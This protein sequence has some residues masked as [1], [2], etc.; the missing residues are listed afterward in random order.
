MT[1][2]DIKTK[3][4][5]CRNELELRSTCSTFLRQGISN[6]QLLNCFE[7]LRS[8]NRNTPQEDIWINVMDALDGWCSI[9]YKIK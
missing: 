8:Y 2:N 5:K 7:E 1:N 4:L 3:I 6:K 9:H